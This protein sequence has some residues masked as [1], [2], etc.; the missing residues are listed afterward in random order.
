MTQ[1][2]ILT[3][4]ADSV[5][6]A[7]DAV[8]EAD[9]ALKAANQKKREAEAEFIQAMHE[10]GDIESIRALGR[11]FTVYRKLTVRRTDEDALFDWLEANSYGA[12]IKRTVHP[13]T[14]A[15]VAGE[16]IEESGEV[17]A[18]L[19]TQFIDLVSVRKA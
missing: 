15:K 3:Q 13:A 9:A 5:L 6:L 19:E 2:Q 11:S 1:A 16:V 4:R 14:L 10:A 8:A 7:R 17:P 12:V 18:G